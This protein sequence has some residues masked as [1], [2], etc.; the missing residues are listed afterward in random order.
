MSADLLSLLFSFQPD[1]EELKQK[2]AYDTQVQQF[3]RQVS[4]VSAQH[5]QKG[6]ETQQDVLELLNPS[7][8]SISYIYALQARISA[9]ADNPRSQKSVPEQL[10]PGGALWNKI[11]L[12]LETA[13][14]V[15]LRYVGSIWARLVLYLEQV[16]R[17]MGTPAL[18]IA[19]IRSA[20]QRLDPT[21]GTFT[22]THLQFIRLCM[23]TR[24]YAAAKPILD[25]YIHSLPST[26]PLLVKEL[27]YSVPSA[28][29]IN[30]GEYIHAKSGHSDKIGASDVQEYYVLG[31]MAY[32]GLQEYKKALNFLEH[33]LIVPSFNIANGLMLEAYKKWVLLS[34]LVHGS[35]Q[36]I[37]RT[38]NGTAIKL[39]KGAAK[40]YEA[41]AEAF[42]QIN[43]LPKLRAQ[44]NAGRDTWAEDGNTGLV[45]QLLDNQ[46]RFYVSRLSRTFS[47]I[48]VANISN[49]LGGTV[50]DLTQYLETLIAS[51][52][53]NAQIERTNK[54]DLGIVLRFYLDPTQGPQAK[55]EKQQQQAL[56]EQTAR[57]NILAEQ[58][59][60]A[61]YRLS[62]TKEYVEHLK[63]ANKKA[64]AAASGEAM[65]TS[66]DENMV[67]LEEEDIMGDL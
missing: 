56:F 16:A 44:A 35:V 54:P 12:F 42:V 3:I 8:N 22:T 67:D 41:L 18:A 1:A 28:D 4:N 51:G 27:E 53:L 14:P 34:C 20:M 48:P 57:T 24:S 50:E 52:H 9:I 30:S 10:R 49:N 32:I 45:Q 26:I 5:F 39:I 29:H 15:Q 2:T 23:E 31:G 65:D 59:R 55:T 46:Y 47:A 61:D 6:A 33:V 58:V 62:L 37:P 19:P 64:T 63:R 25:N 60:S 11:V 66:W 17:V 40:A 36:A 21:T 43:N 13:D 38:A 7:V